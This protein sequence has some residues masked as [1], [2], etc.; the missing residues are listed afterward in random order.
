MLF[1]CCPGNIAEHID[2][3]GSS[4]AYYL[5]ASIIRRAHEVG[6]FIQRASNCCFLLC[7][8]MCK[9]IIDGNFTHTTRSGGAEMCMCVFR[10]ANFRSNIY[11]ISTLQRVNGNMATTH[12]L[13]ASA[14]L[15]EL[16]IGAHNQQCLP[17]YTL[18]GSWKR[19]ATSTGCFTNYG[20][21]TSS[22]KVIWRHTCI[23]R[24]RVSVC[25]WPSAAVGG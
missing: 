13:C 23:N 11:T 20:H 17:L 18:C 21:H 15:L 12:M 22:S 1:V 3:D 8:L 6:V 5:H 4:P 14:L 19:P 25:V 10:N 16:M 24:L 7:G 2:V 9:I